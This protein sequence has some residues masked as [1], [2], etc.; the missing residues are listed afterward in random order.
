MARLLLAVL[1]GPLLSQIGGVPRGHAQQVDLDRPYGDGEIATDRDDSGTSETDII[2]AP[3][4]VPPPPAWPLK[5][6]SWSLDDASAAGAVDIQ[7]TPQRVWR[8]TFGAERRTPSRANI[9]ASALDADVVL[10]Q[11]VR[12]M[13]HARL[14][15]PAR[16]WRVIVSRQV[17]QP[18]LAPPEA[19][20]SW[21]N[22]QR[23]GTTAV[24]VR[25]R[26][27]VRISGQDHILETVQHLSDSGGPPETAAAVAVR[28][29]VDGEFI[30][31]V[32]AELAQSCAEGGQRD[33][34][35]TDDTDPS[36]CRVLK[37]WIESRR[38][39]ERIVIGGPHASSVITHTMQVA[40]LQVLR[41]A[42]CPR[43][44]IA[45]AGPRSGSV[46]G[47]GSPSD[48]AL[49][50]AV[51]AAHFQASTGCLARLSINASS[52]TP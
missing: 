31:F 25:Y 3:L 9:D 2:A 29:R 27:G 45:A 36:A 42:D 51:V 4:Y 17:L 5:V 18:V 23:T 44:G 22:A 32:S 47:L 38:A 7:P 19:G 34:P 41:D 33:V 49:A 39:S 46:A 11:G 35:Q 52:A 12:L 13:A 48:G 20:P 1:L 14:L 37:R 16:D 10:L 24:A 8:H 50:I 30:W 15:F 40:G 6:A 43:Q 28:L 21:G 26:R